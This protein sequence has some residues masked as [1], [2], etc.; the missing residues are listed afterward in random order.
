MNKLLDYYNKEVNSEFTNIT[1]GFQRTLSSRDALTNGSE[2]LYLDGL[3]FV[4]T[5]KVKTFYIP[6]RPKAKT[7]VLITVSAEEFN[8]IPERQPKVEEG[9]PTPAYSSGNALL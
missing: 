8:R 2:G 3:A 6:P 4:G 7:K 9:T 5:A 1:T